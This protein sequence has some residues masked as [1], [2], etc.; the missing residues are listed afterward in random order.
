MKIIGL[1]GGIGSG[2]ST[3][4]N[5]FQDIGVP[6]YI[7]D[8]K[9]KRLM[10]DN[11]EIVNCIKQIFGNKAYEDGK[12]NRALIAQQVFSNKDLLNQLNDIVHPAVEE[13][14]NIWVRQQEDTKKYVIKEAA[15]LFENGGYKKCNFTILVTAPQ[16]ERIRRVITRDQTNRQAVLDR[17]RNQW[18]DA[19]KVLLSDFVIKNMD[20]KKTSLIINKIHNKIISNS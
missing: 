3:V 11:T 15:I 1:T 10:V 2:K 18:S 9:A 7:A 8:D 4:A 6:V 17:I 19:K 16:E 14:F 12:L 5:M 20:L 13:D